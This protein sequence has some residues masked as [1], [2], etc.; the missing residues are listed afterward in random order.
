MNQILAMMPRYRHCTV[1]CSECDDDTAYTH[2]SQCS[3]VLIGELD[4]SDAHNYQGRVR[5]SEMN[6]IPG[7]GK[8]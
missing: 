2:K 4:K 7:P 5:Y 6:D 8:E 1:T 3:T